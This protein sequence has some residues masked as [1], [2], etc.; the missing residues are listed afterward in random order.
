MASWLCWLCLTCYMTLVGLFLFL[1]EVKPN[2]EIYIIFKTTCNSD[3]RRNQ[4]RNRKKYSDA[5]QMVFSY[6]RRI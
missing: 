6:H 3:V 5:W 4:T 2:R 1:V